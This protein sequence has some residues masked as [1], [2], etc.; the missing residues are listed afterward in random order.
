MLIGPIYFL[1]TYQKFCVAILIYTDI[2]V[3]VL[4]LVMARITIE[5]HILLKKARS[6]AKKFNY[7]DWIGHD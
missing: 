7:R 4:F 5:S 1:E 6:D 2:K 3:V